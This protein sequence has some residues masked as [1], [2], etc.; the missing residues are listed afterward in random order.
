[1]ECRPPQAGKRNPWKTTIAARPPRRGGG[2]WAVSRVSGPSKISFARSGAKT[3]ENLIHGFRYAPPVATSHRPFGAK[4]ADPSASG[5]YWQI[6][7]GYA[8]ANGCIGEWMWIKRT[9]MSGRRNLDCTI[10]FGV[11]YVS[12][13]H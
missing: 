6:L 3:K 13:D 5:I 12:T 8:G 10:H 9:K 7:R 1:M 11:A 2:D 4:N